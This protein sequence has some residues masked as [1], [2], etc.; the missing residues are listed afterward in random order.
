MVDLPRFSLLRVLA[1]EAERLKSEVHRHG[2]L[3]LLRPFPLSRITHLHPHLSRAPIKRAY[4]END[5]SDLT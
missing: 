2:D 3:G 5:G 1:L 4:T